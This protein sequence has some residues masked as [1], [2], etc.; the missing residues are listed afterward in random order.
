[1]VAD[2]FAMTLPI[3]AGATGTVPLT[4]R[5]ARLRLGVTPD[6]LSGGLLGGMVRV[7]EFSPALSGLYPTLT[8]ASISVLISPSADLEMAGRRCGAISLALELGGVS[9]RLGVVPA[10]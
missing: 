6:G 10:R 1:L 9:A 4:I 8:P 3:S 2:G 5:D 7:S